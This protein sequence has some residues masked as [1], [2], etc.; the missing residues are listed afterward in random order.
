MRPS[1][2]AKQCSRLANYLI[3]NL[4]MFSLASLFFLYDALI[5]TRKGTRQVCTN[6]THTHTI[7]FTYKHAQFQSSG[8]FAS[9]LIILFLY[10][11]N[12]T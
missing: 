9:F 3:F 1:L 7:T 11:H 2:M 4:A 12:K 8:S 10:Y 5:L 6:Y